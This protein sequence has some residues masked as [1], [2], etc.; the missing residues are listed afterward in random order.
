MQSLNEELNTINTELTSKIDELDHAHSDLRN[1]FE[2]TEIATIFL[3]RN[4][5]VRTFTPAASTFFSL[6]QAD[7]GRPLTQLSTQVDYPELKQHI[8]KVF[9]TGENLNHNLPRDARGRFHM[10]HINPYRD[11]SSS[12]QGVVVTLVDVTTL[13]EAEE[14]QHVLISE[15]NHRVKNML[16]VIASITS[17][18]LENSASKEE[19]AEAL[20]GRLQAMAR[21]YGLLSRE[22]WKEASVEEL[23]LQELEPFGIERIRLEGSET[24][25]VPQQGLSLSMAIHELATNEIRR[26]VKAYRHP[27]HH[28]V[29]GR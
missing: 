3:D 14:H 28:L 5:V 2:S 11:K 7:V 13:A 9:A 8:E 18:T 15:L 19:F 27:R 12:T 6:R 29:G 20:I 25:L 21:A 23:L 16:A 1:L 17:R 26:T 24:K 10:V 4:L 22:S